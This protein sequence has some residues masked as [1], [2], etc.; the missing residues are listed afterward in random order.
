VI[1]VVVKSNKTENGTTLLRRFNKRV[2]GAG[3]LSK[4]KSLK[5]R[6]RKVS[7]FVKKKN[8]LRSIA[9]RQK[10]EKMLKLGQAPKKKKRRY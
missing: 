1:N 7:D 3:V 4:A 5:F 2:Q 10:V 6:D 8:R 9:K